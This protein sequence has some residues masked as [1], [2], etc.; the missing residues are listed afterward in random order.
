[1]KILVTGVAGFIGSHLTEALLV[2]GH[3][4]VGVDN[5][6][7]YYDPTLK[8]ARLARFLDSISFHRIDIANTELLEKVFADERPDAVCHLAAQAGVRYSLENPFV[9]G[10]SNA[11]GTINVLEFAHR[12]GV[13]N[14]VMAS[15]S[16]VYG[17]GLPQPFSEDLITDSPVSLYAA[18]KR[19]TELFAHAYHSLY[20]MH[21]SCLR[22]FTCYGPY[23]R[24]DMSL[25]IFTKHILE[26]KP[27]D[28]FN[29]GDMRRDFTYVSDTVSG[30]IAA[31]NHQEGFQIYNL[32]RG[33]SVALMDFIHT[34][35]RELDIDAKINLLPMQ[36]GDVP[37]TYADITKAKQ[38]LGFE[39]RVGIEEG[40]KKF[41]AWYRSYYNV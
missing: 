1:M 15:S 30:I 23:G 39:P 21:V 14:V 3:T 11:V 10:T 7:N 22:F 5:V 29:N 17:E 28:V 2:Q 6:N 38:K 16:S 25:F 24:P 13:K 41:V 31:L 36:K 20:G 40:V 27:I 9:Y 37:A 32:G 34:I 18:T 35:E 4:V 12:Y 8:E 19:A 33:E 26:G